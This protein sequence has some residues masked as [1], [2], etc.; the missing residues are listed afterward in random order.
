MENNKN[1]AMKTTYL[2]KPLLLTFVA[3]LAMSTSCEKEYVMP[4]ETTT[5]ANTF[6][7]Y[8]NDVLC[9]SHHVP[10]Y[11]GN[12]KLPYDVSY[13]FHSLRLIFMCYGGESTNIIWRISMGIES[14]KKDFKGK[15]SY[16]N[17]VS[18]NSG[19]FWIT[20]ENVGEIELIQFDT[21]NH[22]VSGKFSIL[23]IPANNS[24]KKITG[25]SIINITDGQFDVKIKYY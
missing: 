23:N 1:N 4:P 11:L 2:I 21:I 3:I 13:T 18:M 19:D 7:W 5:G 16:L 10:V 6:G 14:P 22:I 24:Y 15:I 17:V 12:T 8:V 20:C 25:D 9:T